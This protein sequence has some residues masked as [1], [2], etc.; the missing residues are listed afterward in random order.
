MAEMVKRGNLSSKTG[1]VFHA[2]LASEPIVFFYS[3]SRYGYLHR[4]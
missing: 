1:K 3:D 2:P 4:E